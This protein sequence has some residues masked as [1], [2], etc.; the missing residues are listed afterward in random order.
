METVKFYDE[1]SKEEIEFFV[2][3][4]TR[5]NGNTYLLVTEEAEGDSEAFIMEEVKGEED[6]LVYEMVEDDEV[7]EGLAKIFAELLDDVD[8]SM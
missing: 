6:E 3:E 7:L 8:F 5:L 2:L 1:D 4:Q